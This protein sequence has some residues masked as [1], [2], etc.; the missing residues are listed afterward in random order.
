MEKP[1][2]QGAGA[3]ATSLGRDRRHRGRVQRDSSTSALQGQHLNAVETQLQGQA[4]SRG[5][6]QG[7]AAALERGMVSPRK[8]PCPLQQALALACPS[9]SQST[10]LLPALCVFLPRTR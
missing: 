3:M 8:H 4:G 7:P 10:A 2:T 5:P 9:P 6:G 1:D